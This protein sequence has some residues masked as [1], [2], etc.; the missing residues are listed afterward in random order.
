ME[1]KVRG[2]GL[3]LQKASFKLAKKGDEET[4]AAARA[5]ATNRRG[6]GR[7]KWHACIGRGTDGD[8]EGGLTGS[9]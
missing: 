6:P 7:A 3:V 5:K 4:P 9:R 8:G 1:V 2:G